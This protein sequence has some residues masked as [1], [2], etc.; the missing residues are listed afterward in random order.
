MSG[1]SDYAQNKVIDA[2]YRAQAISAPA[3][4]YHALLTCTKGARGNS[5]AYALND[6]VAVTAND[7]IIH[8][9][10][11]TTAGTTAASQASLYPGAVGEAIVDGTASLASDF[12]ERPW[13]VES[14]VPAARASSTFAVLAARRF[15]AVCSGRKTL[16]SPVFQ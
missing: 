15:A 16:D 7:G 12:C 9:Y 2:I 11:V 3:T 6:T 8:L 14:S 10:K 13:M 4:L 5:T 1:L